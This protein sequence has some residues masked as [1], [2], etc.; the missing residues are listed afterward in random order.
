MLNRRTVYS[1]MLR[2]GAPRGIVL[3]YA[4][5]METVAYHS[6]LSTGVGV[7]RARWDAIPQGCPF[8][9]LAVGLLTVP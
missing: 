9:M 1:T 3:A 7:P 2:A 6:V 4:S 8:S 5:Y